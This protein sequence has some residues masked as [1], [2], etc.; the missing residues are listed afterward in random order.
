MPPLN[1]HGVSP[2]PEIHPGGDFHGLQR[3]L[4]MFSVAVAICGAI[5]ALT[6]IRD[7]RRQRVIPR[8]ATACTCMGACLRH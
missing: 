4:A 5:C 7:A 3:I 6:I 1:A 2:R 8:Q